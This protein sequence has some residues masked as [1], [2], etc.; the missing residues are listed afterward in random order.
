[1]PRKGEQA[2]EVDDLDAKILKELVAD[3]RQSFR[4][5]AQKLGV[6][7]AT[8]AKRVEKLE[9]SGIIK[10]YTAVV[11]HEKLGYDLTAVIEI[12]ISEGKLLEVE[13]ELARVPNVFVVYDVTGQSDS[14]IIAKFRS[15]KELNDLVKRILAMKYVERTNTRVVLNTVKEN[16]SFV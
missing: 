8:V 7:T 1:V 2:F 16:V 10:G 14:I 9:K 4:K 5:I 15:R 12:T 6:S 11:D 3:A 13:R